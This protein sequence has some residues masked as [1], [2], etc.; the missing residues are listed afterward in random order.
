MRKVYN[1]VADEVYRKAMECRKIFNQIPNMVMEELP[2]WLIHEH[3][4]IRSQARARF[5]ELQLL[6]KG[7]NLQHRLSDG[8][9]LYGWGLT[10]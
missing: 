7:Y 9:V 10:D 3:S 4:T 1:T 8:W 2:E 5:A 6:S